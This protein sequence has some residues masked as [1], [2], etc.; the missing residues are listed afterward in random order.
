MLKLDENKLAS[1]RRFDDVLNEKYGSE[2]SVERKEFDA[3]AKHGIMQNCL[4]MSVKNRILPK[5]HWLK[6]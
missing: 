4:R 6:K 1:L 2:K 3:K 5:S